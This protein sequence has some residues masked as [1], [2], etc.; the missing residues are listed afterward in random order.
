[1]PYSLSIGALPAAERMLQIA[2]CRLHSHEQN[3]TRI[4]LRNCLR[5]HLIGHV[6]STFLYCRRMTHSVFGVLVFVIYMMAVHLSA[7]PSEGLASP[8]PFIR[9]ET[10]KKLRLTTKR[11]PKQ[12]WD[13][14]MKSIKAAKN[15]ADVWRIAASFHLSGNKR[16]IVRDPDT[17][18]LIMDEGMSDSEDYR[19]DNQWK[20]TVRYQWGTDSVSGFSLSKHIDYVWVDPPSNFTGS[21]VVYY[22][23][24]VPAS[25]IEYRSGQ[26]FGTLIQFHPN[27]LTKHVQH[28]TKLGC[29]G[30]DVEYYPSGR[31]SYR[32]RWRE[33]V[34]VP[35]GKWVWF[36]ENGKIL[37]IKDFKSGQIR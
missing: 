28:Y 7:A 21:W 29:D 14:L 10:A 16:V 37:D 11:I 31:I 9:D 24:G 6:V 33:G 26:Y 3:F 15:Q 4:R 2:H 19:L 23:N 12:K 30:P 32:G 17:G 5:P 27:G 36:R 22:V 35:V 25:N 34:P 13:P 18:A 1:V 20:L 8:S